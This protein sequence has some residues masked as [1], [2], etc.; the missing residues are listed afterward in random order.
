M[1]IHSVNSIPSAAT[2]AQ[3]TSDTLGKSTHTGSGPLPAPANAA[4]QSRPE[5][6]RT[7]STLSR[8]RHVPLPPSEASGSQRFTM[9]HVGTDDTGPKSLHTES[10]LSRARHVPLPP[11]EAS[12]SQ[13][14]TTPSSPENPSQP[15]LTH[16]GSD[17]AGNSSRTRFFFNWLEQGVN[18]VKQNKNSFEPDVGTSDAA[19]AEV[20]RQLTVSAT[21]Q[22]GRISAAEGQDTPPQPV[23][24]DNAPSEAA[25][26]SRQRD[27][28]RVASTLAQGAT[29]LFRAAAGEVLT[30]PTIMAK[31][32]DVDQ[33]KAFAGH[34]IHQT[35]SVGLPTFARELLAYGVMK[36][37][38]TASMPVAVSAQAGVGLVNF[39]LQVVR[40]IRERR[41]PDEAA[42]A[43]HSL[44]PEEWQAKT[45][46][47]KEKLL[48]TQR[49]ASRMVTQYQVV[50]SMGNMGLMIKGYAEGDIA[51]AV[52][53]LGTEVKTTFYAL[54]RDTLQA[55]FRMVGHD[56][57]PAPAG[58]AGQAMMAAAAGYAMA[59]TATAFAGDALKGQLVPLQGD[60]TK[61]LLGIPDP[62]TGRL[63]MSPSEAWA[64]TAKTAAISAAMNVVAETVDWHNRTEQELRQVGAR[65]YFDGPHITADDYGRLLDQSTSRAALINFLN[66]AASAA[67]LAVHNQTP[68]IQQLVGNG[69]FLALSAMSDP[70]IQ[71]LWQ[72]HG[73]V[74]ANPRPTP[75]PD[76]LQPDLEFGFHPSG[77]LDGS[78]SQGI[79]A[80]G[81]MVL[82]RSQELSEI[83]GTP[84]TARKR[85][86]VDLPLPSNASTTASVHQP[87]SPRSGTGT[88]E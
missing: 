44:T 36:A 74:R 79:G 46:E 32:I 77:P 45:P 81:S 49:L 70:S 57:D 13:R 47:Q 6:L 12:E 38:S 23:P 60:A 7:E 64:T 8:A 34:A 65:Q 83:P 4:L 40:E 75:Q 42:R 1:S 67:G 27:L 18:L 28:G 39:G 9:P 88:G 41:N 35:V 82:P 54:S 22:H 62:A 33:A 25:G 37:A 15:M 20:R 52:R 80:S 68:G 16:V 29:A 24:E 66:T 63:L 51:A 72:A 3:G 86:R 21:F 2:S 53:P 43:F 76:V 56:A 58:L 30:V 17:D 5:S 10:T 14:F 48:A 26:A 11:S 71:G 50:A 85:S 55:T 59:N 19:I 84:S 31:A 87:A 69:T 78:S 73:A 61:T